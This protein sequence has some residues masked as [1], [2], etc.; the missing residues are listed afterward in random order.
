MVL[1]RGFVFIALA[2]WMTVAGAWLAQLAGHKPRVEP[3]ES[4]VS[5]R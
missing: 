1:A 3:R 5:S 2:A 4:T